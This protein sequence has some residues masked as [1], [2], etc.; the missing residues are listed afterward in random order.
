MRLLKGILVLF[1]FVLLAYIFQM[2]TI[3]WFVKNGLRVA[4]IAIVI[5]FQPELRRALEKI[6]EKNIFKSMLPFDRSLDEIDINKNNKI[7]SAC[8][9]MKE[10]KT[11]ALIVIEKKTNL[12]EYID[13]GIKIDSYI[14]EEILINIFEHNTP[15]HDGAVIIRNNRIAAATCILP[16]SES[17]VISKSFGTRHRAALGL[18]EVSD[19]IIIIVSEE[20]GEI[21][22]ALDS[23]F[24]ESVNESELFRVLNNTKEKE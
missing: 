4:A 20:T 3:L 13:T 18:S 16:I 2:N 19:A 24:I 22:L 21:S 8:Q 23:K 11:G 17:N 12:K 1:L 15:L 7:I 14:S 10:A 9:K 6:G 5:V